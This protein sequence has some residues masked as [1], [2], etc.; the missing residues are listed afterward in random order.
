MEQLT[1]FDVTE[2]PLDEKQVFDETKANVKEKK[3]MGNDV[4]KYCIIS[5]IIPEDVLSPIELG[6]QG[7]G[8]K[9]GSPE[10]ERRTARWS[11]Y[12]LAIWN[13]EK[14][15]NGRG[16]HGCSW[17]TACKMLQEARDN[18]QPITMRVS[19]NSGYPFY[20]DQVVDYQ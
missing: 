3:W 9:Y 13:Y 19:L 11:D 12:V 15:D 8:L 10:Y 17:E 6:V 16:F 14:W 7:E 20:P 1:I 5:A 2:Q 18:K 4:E